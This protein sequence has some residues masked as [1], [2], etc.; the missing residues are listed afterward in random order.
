M[1]FVYRQKLRY[2]EACENGTKF[3]QHTV[4]TGV[5]KEGLHLF[6]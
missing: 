3:V 5:K 1:C 2:K 6:Q 4:F